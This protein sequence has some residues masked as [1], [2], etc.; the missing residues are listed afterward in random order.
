MMF[1]ASIA[2]ARR[3]RQRLC[4]HPHLHYGRCL[5]CRTVVKYTRK[6]DR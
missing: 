1:A 2:I 6:A 3:R 5:D 4:A